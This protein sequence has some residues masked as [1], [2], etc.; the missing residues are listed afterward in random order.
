MYHL[1]SVNRIPN[2]S[3]CFTVINYPSSPLSE[4]QPGCS[5]G[6]P[7]DIQYRVSLQTQNLPWAVPSISQCTELNHQAR[8]TCNQGVQGYQA[9]T[10]M[11]PRIYKKIVPCSSRQYLEWYLGHHMYKIKSPGKS[12][13]S[14]GSGGGDTVD[15][16]ITN[17]NDF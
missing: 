16:R 11:Y 12:L 8:F 9:G 10:Y 4:Q 17:F 5:R 15:S 13:L 3:Q 2:L 1:I 14:P 7:G 6:L